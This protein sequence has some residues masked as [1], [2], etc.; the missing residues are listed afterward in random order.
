MV[1]NILEYL[2]RTKDMFL[3]YG[4]SKLKESRYDDTN[5]HMDKDDYNS[6]LGIRFLM[7]NIVVNWK[8]SNRKTTID[9]SVESEYITAS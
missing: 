8:S 7:N 2:R 5:F 9:S 6:Q 3:R 1:N 4:K